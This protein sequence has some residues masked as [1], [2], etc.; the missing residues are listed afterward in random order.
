MD[1]LDGSEPSLCLTPIPFTWAGITA[2]AI[3]TSSQAMS[4][5]SCHSNP[6]RP[7]IIN[8]S[9]VPETANPA[10]REYSPS[11][12]EESSGI[13]VYDG[14]KARTVPPPVQS[15]RSIMDEKPTIYLIALKDGTI[16]Q[17]IGYWQQGDTFHYVTP[18]SSI[19]HLSLAM[20]DRDRS[21]ELNAERKLEFDLKAPI[22]ER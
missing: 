17:A 14:P 11:E 20:V 9:Y 5:S 13:R 1:R 22:G 15:G 2:R 16:R 6:R 21:V 19:N 10:L 3:T 18:E 4:P 12:L 8:N 7:V